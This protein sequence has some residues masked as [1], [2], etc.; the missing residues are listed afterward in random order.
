[1]APG[2]RQPGGSSL[3]SSSRLIRAILPRSRHI[4]VAATDGSA[5][6][7]FNEMGAVVDRL[8]A[9]MP[10]ELAILYLVGDWDRGLRY[11]YWGGSGRAGPPAM[12]ARCP[13]TCS[14]ILDPPS[15]TIS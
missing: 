9:V 15:P 5:I 2:A 10:F 12:R 7:N 4:S 13:A 1:M 11:R 3:L 6:E 14:R 8:G